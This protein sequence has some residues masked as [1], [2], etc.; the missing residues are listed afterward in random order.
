MAVVQA[1]HVVEKGRDDGGAGVRGG[2][3]ASG[4]LAASKHAV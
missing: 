3:M 1:R 2:Q 4:R